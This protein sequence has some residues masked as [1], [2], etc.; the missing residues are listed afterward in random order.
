MKTIIST[1][2]IIS[3]GA[4]TF[5][6]DS[7]NIYI[8]EGSD[9]TIKG[10]SNLNKFTCHYSKQIGPSC[11]SIDYQ[12][13]NSIIDLKKVKLELE[14]QHFDCGGHLI[15]KDFNELMKV[16]KHTHISIEFEKVKIK[17]D[18]FD[19]Y[20]KITIADIANHYNFEVIHENKQ[21]YLGSLNLNINDFD[22]KAPKKLLGAIKV[23]PNI[24][25][26][27]DL[28]LEIGKQE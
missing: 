2:L 22:M 13:H 5:M 10:E 9:I 20:A 1:F 15:N 21:N 24:S 28:N 18:H 25:I 16:Q 17:K 11:L 8:K 6:D 12:Q 3:I 19:V 26:V 23:D 4:L 27:F 14:S 7:T